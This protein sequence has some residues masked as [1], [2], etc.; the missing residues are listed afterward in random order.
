MSDPGAYALLFISAF[1]AASLLP[2]YSEAVLIGM[3][4]LGHYEPWSLWITASLGNTAGSVLNWWIARYALRW[5]DRRWFVINP[6]QIDKASAWFR[7]YGVWT[8]LLA[9]APLGGDALTFVAGILRVPL[10]IFI[11]LV[12]IG[13]AARYAVVMWLADTIPTS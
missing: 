9:W 7:R 8:L 13:K 5:Q 2:F 1:G 4:M 6:R 10:V 11:V 12:G 3:M